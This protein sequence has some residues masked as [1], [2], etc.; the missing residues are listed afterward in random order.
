M[1]ML[2]GIDL[3]SRGRAVLEDSARVGKTIT[4]GE[5]ERRVGV[6]VGAWN[7]VDPIYEDCRTQGHPDLTAIIIYKETG[8]PPFYSDGGEAQ[9]K[10]FNPNDLRQVG[11][12]QDEVARVFLIWK[13]S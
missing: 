10:R 5:I 6:K 8:Y 3:I 4:F 13:T 12:W 1:K 9:S 7:K 11:R 2:T